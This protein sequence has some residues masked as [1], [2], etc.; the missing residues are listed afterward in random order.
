MYSQKLFVLV[1]YKQKYNFLSPNFYI[2]VSV[3]D[4]RRMDLPI[5]LQPNRQT[6]P[7]NI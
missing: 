3:S 2:H 7:G 5:L 1:I 6:D 4:I